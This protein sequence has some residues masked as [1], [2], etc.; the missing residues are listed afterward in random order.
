MKTKMT[1]KQYQE[2]EERYG[3]RLLGSYEKLKKIMKIKEE[4]EWNIHNRNEYNELCQF[5]IELMKEYINTMKV[6]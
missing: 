3:L 4:K 2:M 6:L 1:S 5:E